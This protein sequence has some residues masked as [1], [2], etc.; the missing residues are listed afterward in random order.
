MNSKKNEKAGKLIV[1]GIVLLFIP[2][3][4]FIGFFM[5]IAGVLM[6]KS[7]E[8]ITM[9]LKKDDISQEEIHAHDFIDVQKDDVSQ[10]QI[11]AHD[12]TQVQQDDITQDQVHAHDSWNNDGPIKYY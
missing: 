2:I 9:Q 7:N 12:F 5:I 11:H 1:W 3:I 6:L 4:N 8:N 10:Q